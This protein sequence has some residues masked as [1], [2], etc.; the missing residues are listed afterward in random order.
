LLAEG[1]KRTLAKL[2]KALDHAL[3]KNRENSQKRSGK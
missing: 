3:P 1:E 2:Q